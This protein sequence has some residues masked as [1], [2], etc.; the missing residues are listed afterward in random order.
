MRLFF[1]AA[2]AVGLGIS[3]AGAQRISRQEPARYAGTERA[4]R[5]RGTAGRIAANAGVLAPVAWRGAL[6]R[7]AIGTWNFWGVD[8]ASGN[9]GTA[10][11]Q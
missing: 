1:I 3:I 2:C 5:H 11:P 4:S 8:E 9:R 6:C 7:T 10:S